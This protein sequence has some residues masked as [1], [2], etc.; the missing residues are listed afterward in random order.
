MCKVEE[1]TW[2]SP[3]AGRALGP[4]RRTCWLALRP[5]RLALGAPGCGTPGQGARRGHGR[6]W[7]QVGRAW[8]QVGC[9]GSRLTMAELLRS[10][11]DSQLVAR[12]QRR[13]GLFP[14]PEDNPRE[15][16]AGSSEGTTRVPEVAHLPANPQVT[17]DSCLRG[18]KG[19]GRLHV[20]GSRRLRDG[21]RGLLPPPPSI[22]PREGMA[23][24]SH[25]MSPSVAAGGNYIFSDNTQSLCMYPLRDS[26]L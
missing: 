3:R 9:A 11:Q 5:A 17:T 18:E 20:C 10:L 23:G 19:D 14:A 21:D 7:L 13:C 24:V 8:L 12:F 26:I 6:A 2:V 15:N 4:G 1:D 22:G 16:S 25:T